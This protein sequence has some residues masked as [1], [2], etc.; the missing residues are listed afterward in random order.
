MKFDDHLPPPSRHDAVF[1][2]HIRPATMG[3]LDRC[4]RSLLAAEW[5]APDSP[6]RLRND[7]SLDDVKQARFFDQTRLF[8]QLLT[9]NKG[10]P[11]TAAG[12]LNRAYVAQMVERMDWPRQYMKRF[13]RLRMKKVDEADVS[14]L[15][16]I[17]VVCECGYLV[18]RR[19]H[20]MYATRKARALCEDALAGSLYHHLFVAFFQSFNLDYL[21]GFRETPLVQDSIAVILWRLS[22]VADDWIAVTRLPEQVLLNQV[23][24]Q[25]AKTFP[26]PYMSDQDAW[27]LNFHVLEPLEWFGLLENDAP[28]DEPF[29]RH[30]KMRFRKTSLFDRFM[31]FECELR[32]HNT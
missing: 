9:E 7:L 8:L 31:R 15:N 20:R 23:R 5:N 14:P 6:I 1:V 25:I 30:E 21:S 17:R 26:S 29:H 24:E 16:I 2:P 12:N 11:L 13:E 22:L 18:T 3:D 27:I 28:D 19:R 4:V 10:A 32:G